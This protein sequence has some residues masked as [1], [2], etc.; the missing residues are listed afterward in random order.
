MRHG[1]KGCKN[2]PTLHGYKEREVGFLFTS[3]TF[4]IFLIPLVIVGMF[5]WFLATTE[6]DRSN[7]EVGGVLVSPVEVELSI[8]S[9][10]IT[11]ESGT[12]KLI[13]EMEGKNVCS[14][15]AYL[16]PNNFQ[17]LLV[18]NVNPT[19]SLPPRRV[20]NPMNYT[21]DCDEAPASLS[22]I[23]AGAVRSVTLVFYAETLPRGEDWDD[24]HL[25]LEY[26]DPTTPL[27]LSTLLNP[28]EE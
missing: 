5:L 4:I 2:K 18:E 3:R 15:D 20:Y 19:A 9:S 17:L 13:V 23:P 6:I 11:H 8:N 26:Y 25:S 16:N 28:A 10:R 21:T 24:F 14:V 1:N 22:R 12:R 7:V 27:M